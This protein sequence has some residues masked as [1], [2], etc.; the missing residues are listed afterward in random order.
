MLPG[1]Q[2]L[3]KLTHLLLAPFLLLLQLLLVVMKVR[4]TQPAAAGTRRGRWH[5]QHRD[6]QPTIAPPP[7]TE[8]EACQLLGE[9][10][11][12]CNG[13]L[14]WWAAH[15]ALND[16]IIILILYRPGGS[17]LLSHHL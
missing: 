6:L 8:G 10:S 1:C 4:I 12:L 2:G 13:L 7:A 14:A 17:L 5:W 3:P 11:V 9:Q 15:R 16:A